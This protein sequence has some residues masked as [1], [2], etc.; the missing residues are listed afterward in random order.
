MAKEEYIFLITVLKDNLIRHNLDVMHIEK[1]VGEV[2]LKWLDTQRDKAHDNAKDDI[3]KINRPPKSS[4]PRGPRH[5]LCVPKL[6]KYYKI[7]SVQTKLMCD[8]LSGVKVPSG[9][10]SNIARCFSSEN[11]T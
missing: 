7:T 5:P 4:V 1:N 8:V 9:Y 6:H 10:S 3:K 2:L 11:K